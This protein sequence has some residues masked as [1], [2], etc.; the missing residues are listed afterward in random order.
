MLPGFLRYECQQPYW[1]TQAP[2]PNLTLTLHRF[3]RLITFMSNLKIFV[4]CLL[5]LISLYKFIKYYFKWKLKSESVLM[6][7]RM[8]ESRAM[9]R[10]V[11]KATMEFARITKL[12][13]A[14]I[15]NMSNSSGLIS[16]YNPSPH[17]V[18]FWHCILSPSSW[19]LCSQPILNLTFSS[20]CFFPLLHLKNNNLKELTQH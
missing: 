12:P 3:S 5:F 9:Q 13:L 7:V 19:D 17:W 6:K 2:L 1:E 16:V 15:Y 18:C 14:H 4:L 11:S 20:F 10:G 8:G